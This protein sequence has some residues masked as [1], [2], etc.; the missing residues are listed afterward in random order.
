M[1]RKSTARVTFKADKSN[2]KNSK[3]AGVKPIDCR[4]FITAHF[5]IL[6]PIF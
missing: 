5:K 6:P 3:L 1:L 2:S 4:T